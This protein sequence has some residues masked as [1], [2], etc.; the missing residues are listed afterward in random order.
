[1][2]H[3]EDSKFRERTLQRLEILDALVIAV[4]RRAELMR[5]V[6]EA[7]R[8]EEARREASEVLGL[9]ETQA[10]AVLDL[11]IWRFAAG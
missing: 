9:N 2:G 6:A 1:M 4:D 3:A 7:P 5:T 8:T 11:K 10:V